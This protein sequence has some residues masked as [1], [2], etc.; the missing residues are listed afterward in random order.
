MLALLRPRHLLAT[1]LVAVL[2]GSGAGGLVGVARAQDADVVAQV[3]PPPF[4]LAM[5]QAGDMGRYVLE[6]DPAGLTDEE[7]RAGFGDVRAYDVDFTM[8]DFEVQY[9]VSGVAHWARR[10]QL[11]TFE[12]SDDWNR[13]RQADVWVVDGVAIASWTVDEN[14]PDISVQAGPLPGQTQQTTS[15]TTWRSFSFGAT[16][17]PCGLFNRFQGVPPP[18]AGTLLEETLPCAWGPGPQDPHNKHW[19]IVRGLDDKGFLVVDHFSTHPDDRPWRRDRPDWT[20]WYRADIPYPAKMWSSW[21]EFGGP[22]DV[23]RL[24]GFERGGGDAL[25]PD[26]PLPPSLP[27]VERA[28]TPVWGMDDTGVDHPFPLS[29]AFAYVRDDPATPELRDYLA[30]HPDAFVHWAGH[31]EFDM[32]GVHG[33]RW[34][35]ELTD[36]ESRHQQVISRDET[37]GVTIGPGL[38]GLIPTVTYRYGEADHSAPWGDWLP[39]AKKPATMPTAASLLAVWDA[40]PSFEG[41]PDADTSW[42]FQVGCPPGSDCA[43]P[44]TAVLAGQVYYYRESEAGYPVTDNRVDVWDTSEV[45]WRDGELTGGTESDQVQ[46][47][48]EESVVPIPGATPPPETAIAALGPAPTPSWIAPTPAQAA[49]IGFGAVLVALGYWLWP[50]SKGGM[51]GLFSRVRS[52]RLLE[53]PLRQRIVQRVD[54]EPGIHHNALVRDLGRGKGALEHH[55]DKLVAG[56]L[57][58]RHRTRGYTCYFPTGTDRRSMAASAATKAEGARKVMAALRPGGSGVREVAAATGL[59]PSTVSHHLQRLREAGLVLGD[60]LNGYRAAQPEVVAA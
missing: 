22:R 58:L 18:P 55:L 25:V 23:L 41:N 10:V 52:D 56:R 4:V 20:A 53:N 38:P 27:A 34:S 16:P 59:A 17:M 35:F 44:T 5:P 12:S 36:G 21:S 54:A 26:L 29:A 15:Q 19:T 39:P 2:L 8:G 24:V 60:G 48:G 47:R 7:R 28:P 9:G 3:M 1:F 6:I 51:L 42:S 50:L 37:Y 40:L 46:V 13:S 43:T 57:L 14:E 49:G 11:S 31:A 32:D 33:H 45:Y 30:A